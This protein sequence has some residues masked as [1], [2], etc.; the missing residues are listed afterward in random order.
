MRGDYSE[1]CRGSRVLYSAAGAGFASSSTPSAV[2]GGCGGAGRAVS[3]SVCSHRFKTYVV[4]RGRPVS[5]ASC[6]KLGRAL[7][8]AAFGVVKGESNYAADKRVCVVYGS[9]EDVDVYADVHAARSKEIARLVCKFH[10]P[11]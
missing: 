2:L 8:P 3:C 10:R 6:S 4:F 11:R 1:P 9:R 5:R 7:G